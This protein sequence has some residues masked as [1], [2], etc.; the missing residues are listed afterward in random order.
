MSIDKPLS[1][2]EILAVVSNI[3][4]KN[5]FSE[6][7]SIPLKGIDRES[8][9]LFE[10]VYS[11]VAVVAFPNW[12][13]LLEGWMEAQSALVEL[14]SQHISQEEAK[15][16]EGYL[17]MLTTSLVPES[18]QKQIEQIRY[19]TSRIRK[20]VTTGTQLQEISDVENAL[21]PFLQIQ[22]KMEE[23]PDEAVLGR[24]PDLLHDKDISQDMIQTVVD[25][26][27]KQRP[28][29]ETL[30]KYRLERETEKN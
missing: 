12:Q 9:R 27:T 16:W 5:G 17:A 24:L 2:T 29:I 23:S 13:G 10:D 3:L 14:I 19:D 4:S 1:Q 11:I 18:A 26:F 7:E 21:L 20:L 25:A 28:L 8:Y 6:I 30:H 22:E 15:R